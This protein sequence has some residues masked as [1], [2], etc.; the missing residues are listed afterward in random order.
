MNNFFTSLTGVNLNIDPVI[1]EELY[2]SHTQIRNPVHRTSI[3]L[4]KSP[5]ACKGSIDCDKDLPDT[6]SVMSMESIHTEVSGDH[7]RD[8]SSAANLRHEYVKSEE[9]SLVK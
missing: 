2:Q 9:S 4:N 8:L 5:W 7:K 6:S 3:S 1:P